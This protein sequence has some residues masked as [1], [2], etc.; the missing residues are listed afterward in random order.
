MDP[1]SNDKCPYKEKEK[2]HGDSH[3]MTEAELQV[4]QP[5]A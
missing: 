4:T 3:V 1:G 5:Q 2:T